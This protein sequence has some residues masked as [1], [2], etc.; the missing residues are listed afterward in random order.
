MVQVALFK[1][2]SDESLDRQLLCSEE[3]MEKP[4]WTMHSLTS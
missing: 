3:E 1:K 4:A 2:I